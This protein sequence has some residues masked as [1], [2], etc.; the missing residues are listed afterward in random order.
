MSAKLQ[1]YI[2]SDTQWLKNASCFLDFA[3]KSQRGIG[4]RKAR[5]FE[6]TG[7][8]ILTSGAFKWYGLT[9]ELV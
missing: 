9:D 8:E 1:I 4:G 7:E 6:D 3:V 5:A 2:L